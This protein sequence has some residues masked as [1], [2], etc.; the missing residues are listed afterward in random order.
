MPPIRQLLSNADDA[1]DSVRQVIRAYHGSP[2]DFDK[3]NAAKIG[4]GEGAQSYGHGLYFAGNED[5]ARYYKEALSDDAPFSSPAEAAADYLAASG[6]NRKM[7]LKILGTHASQPASVGYTKADQ[8][9]LIR[10][11][12]EVLASNA[13]LVPKRR[14]G[15]MYEVEIAHPEKSLLDLDATPDEQPPVVRRALENLG[16]VSPGPI[17]PKNNISGFAA[18]RRLSEDR[19]P[20]EAAKALL[21][22]GVPGARYFDGISR[23]QKDGSRNYVM[24]PGTEDQIRI[25]R[26][27]GLLAP[28]AAGAAASG[29]SEPPAQ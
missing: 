18:M 28:V 21:G 3:F 13:D 4:T 26:K 8:A 20:A 12:Y 2:Y 22:E 29:A 7:A 25:L 23:A 5:T 16:L 27:Y 6:G 9:Q 24:F 17:T 11:A 19:S 10:Q 14:A 15:R 1:G